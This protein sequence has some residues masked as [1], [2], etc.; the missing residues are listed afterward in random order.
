VTKG[1]RGHTAQINLA[2]GDPRLS[3]FCKTQ[4]SLTVFGP[5]GHTLT[6]QKNKMAATQ[7]SISGGLNGPTSAGHNSV[8]SGPILAN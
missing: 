3:S 7:S 8:T 6:A 2:M 1:H 4:H 5:G